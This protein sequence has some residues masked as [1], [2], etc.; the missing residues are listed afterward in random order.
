M[1]SDPIVYNYI[2][3]KFQLGSGSYEAWRDDRAAVGRAR[4]GLG[5]LM[6]PPPKNTPQV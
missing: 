4:G 6:V 2:V 1:A 5:C 3:T